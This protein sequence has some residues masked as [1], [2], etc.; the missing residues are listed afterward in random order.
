V[1]LS[2]LTQCDACG[3]PLFTPPGRWFQ[4]VRT[5]GAIIR[6]RALELLGA[7]ALQGVSLERLE[8]C[9]PALADPV[10]VLGD[11]DPRQLEEL[12]LCVPCY[13]ARPLADVVRRRR[14]RIEVLSAQGRVS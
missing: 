3:G 2:Q 13:H 1:K 7:A 6:T 8:S 12:L 4:V 11:L 10:D 9:G 14:E 5:S